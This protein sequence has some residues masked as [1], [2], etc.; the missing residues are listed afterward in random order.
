MNVIVRPTDP[1]CATARGGRWAIDYVKR[2]CAAQRS[3]SVLS[4]L[5]SEAL[6][7]EPF[8]RIR[9][10]LCYRTEPAA[11]PA[12]RLR[13]RSAH[14]PARPFCR[15]PTYILPNAPPLAERITA[16]ATTSTFKQSDKLR[17]PKA[18]TLAKRQ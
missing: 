11:G 12:V 17:E 18:L 7:R 2:A 6:G 15:A 1:V 3:V 14:D 4:G 10:E 16:S 9:V 5:H 8:A 13:G